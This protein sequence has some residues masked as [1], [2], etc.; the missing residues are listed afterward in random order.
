MSPSFGAVLKKGGKTA[1]AGKESPE[2]TST[3]G[4]M[5]MV[6]AVIFDF[7]NILLAFADIM[8]GIGTI[9]AIPV[10]I[11]AMGFI[12][13]WLFLRTGKLPIKRAL[14]PFGLNSL[15]L[16]RFFPFWVWAV[17]SSCKK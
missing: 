5:M 8:F 4:I 2:L 15:P 16:I 13:G 17:W 11:M 9:I 14:L 1:L 7:V 12:G 10:N 6:V 3:E